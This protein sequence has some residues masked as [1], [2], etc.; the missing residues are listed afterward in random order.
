MAYRGDLLQTEAL[1]LDGSGDPITGASITI[2]ASTGPGGEDLDPD[3]FDWAEE[4]DGVYLVTYQ[5]EDTDLYGRYYV[6]FQFDDV[7]E[8]IFETE[9]GEWE[10][11]ID[12]PV[13]QITAPWSARTGSNTN[14]APSYIDDDGTFDSR[15]PLRGEASSV[16]HVHGD[17]GVLNF[18][19]TNSIHFTVGGSDISANA[20]FGTTAGTVAE[21][22]ALAAKAA[23]A[24]THAQADVTNL[25]TD[26]AAKASSTHAHSGADITSGTVPIARIPTGTDG[27]TVSLGNHTHSLVSSFEIPIDGAGSTPA[28]GIWTWFKAPFALTLTGWEITSTLAGAIAFDLWKDTYA[29]WPP[30]ISD[31]ISGAATVPLRIAATNSKATSTDFTGW[32]TTTVATGDYIIVN[33]NSVTTITKALLTLNY[34]RTV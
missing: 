13:P 22:S 33:I 30:N 1:L 26:L 29:N 15:Y 21:G 9:D 18:Q 17:L 8:S 10:L 31:S 24:H 25:V 34:T 3:R 20:A 19:S 27:V 2:I 12:R 14:V 11:V 5:T 16:D 6:A 28:T 4:E 23:L 32:T 7:D